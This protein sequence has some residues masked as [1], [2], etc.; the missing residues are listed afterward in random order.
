V[1]RILRSAALAAFAC[2][3]LAGCIDSSGPI[4]SDSQEA[5]GSRL[6]VQLYTL[7]NGRAQNPEQAIF[8]WRGGLYAHAAGGMREVS[9]FSVNPFEN[10]DFIIQEVPA[11]RPRTTEYALLHKIA[12]GVFQVL[13]I[14]EDDA[15]EQTRA[16]YCGQG[17]P[18]NPSSC[19]ITTQEQL[20]AFARAT[21]ARGKQD[22]GLAIVLSAEPERPARHR[23]HHRR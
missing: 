10:G 7:K 13:P 21:A 15:D 12:D 1:I 8:M 4:L 14:D 2:L 19:R 22:G 20:F 9:A 18:K 16:A 6:R 23:R 3:A 11:N 5:F 17:G